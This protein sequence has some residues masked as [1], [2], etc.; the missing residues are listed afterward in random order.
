MYSMVN[1]LT[2]IDLLN[3][4]NVGIPYIAVHIDCLGMFGYIFFAMGLV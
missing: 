3:D 4:P 2:N 1:T